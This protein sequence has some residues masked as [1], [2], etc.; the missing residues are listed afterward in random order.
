MFRASALQHRYVEIGANLAFQRYLISLKPV[1]LFSTA[2]QE[3]SSPQSVPGSLER[4]RSGMESPGQGVV[5]VSPGLGVV[6][7]H[8][9]GL[10]ITEMFRK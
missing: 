8:A 1:T 6:F 3:S 5:L 2:G 9:V 7:Y 4:A 10:I